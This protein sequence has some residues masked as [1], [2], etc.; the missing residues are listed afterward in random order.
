M[1]TNV[2]PL[3]RKS[4]PLERD[5]HSIEEAKHWLDVYSNALGE[6]LERVSTREGLSVENLRRSAELA[7]EIAYRGLHSVERLRLGMEAM[8]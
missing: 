3:P 6:I 5:P 2:I 7:R 1:T 4:C 8:K